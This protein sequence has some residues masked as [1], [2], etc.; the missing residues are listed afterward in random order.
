MAWS[1]APSARLHLRRSKKVTIQPPAKL[2]AGQTNNKQAQ[3]IN[4]RSSSATLPTVKAKGLALNQVD[5]ADEYAK[6]LISPY[7]HATRVPTAYSNQSSLL[8]TRRTFDVSVGDL[9]AGREFAF[10]VQP[11]L[12]D[13]SSPA[14]YQIGLVNMSLENPDLTESSSYRKYDQTGSSLPLDPNSPW[15]TQGTPKAIGIRNSGAAF[16]SQVYPLRGA[17]NW[18]IPV[19]GGQVPLT[20]GATWSQ[21]D[22][23]EGGVGCSLLTVPPGSYLYTVRTVTSAVSITAI[24]YPPS[25]RRG[26]IMDASVGTTTLL[27]STAAGHTQ[28]V[29]QYAMNITEFDKIVLLKAATETANVTDMIITMVPLCS[30]GVSWSSDFGLTEAIRPVGMSVLTTCLMS[31]MYAGGQIQSAMLTGSSKD[32]IFSGNWLGPTGFNNIEG[33]FTGN[34]DEGNYMW[35]RPFS[36]E[37]IQFKGIAQ[38]NQ[39]EYPTMLVKGKIPPVPGE[40]ASAVLCQVTVEFVYEILQ[41]TQL[42]ERKKVVGSTELY[43]SSLRAVQRI[44]YASENPKHSDLL[45]KV[46]KVLDTGAKVLPILRELGGW[47]L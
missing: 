20:Y 11:K 42:L 28:Q 30:P 19:A 45:K 1:D 26:N 40:L 32:K 29:A 39:Y 7:D 24:P 2:K 8:K 6:C 38:A 43:E 9:S 27:Y 46:N 34:F 35:W 33:Y 16:S 21:A 5:A 14:C 36:P 17:T 41:N 25:L 15:I 13:P 3:P 47:F 44:P 4:L 31:K 22:G 23:Q 12:G 10:F 37:D 18:N